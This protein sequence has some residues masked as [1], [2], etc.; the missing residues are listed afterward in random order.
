MFTTFVDL[1][2]GHSLKGQLC[3]L[4]IRASFHQ[5]WKFCVVQTPTF[6]SRHQRGLAIRIRI[7]SLCGVHVHVCMR[8]ALQ[9]SPLQKAWCQQTAVLLVPLWLSVGLFGTRVCLRNRLGNIGRAAGHPL[10]ALHRLGPW[11]L[12]SGNNYFLFTPVFAL[13]RLLVSSSE[14]DCKFDRDNLWPFWRQPLL[15]LQTAHSNQPSIAAELVGCASLI[16][17]LL[18]VSI[19]QNA[20]GHTDS[21]SNPIIMNTE[22]IKYTWQAWHGIRF[23][24]FY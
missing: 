13:Y 22:H 24:L 5:L 17:F 2:A 8:T 9:L 14:M 6:L 7:S 11:R 4:L 18:C 21:L 1:F 20:C 10:S 23:L 3:P 19:W 12:I 15:H 16:N